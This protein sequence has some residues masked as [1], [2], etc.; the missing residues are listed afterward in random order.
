V[1]DLADLFGLIPILSD[2]RRGIE[3]DVLTN[4]IISEVVLRLVTA[5]DRSGA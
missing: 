5:P 2:H 1:P 3:D 4:I